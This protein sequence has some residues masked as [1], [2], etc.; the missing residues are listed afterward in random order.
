MTS[1][2]CIGHRGAKGYMPENTL[3]SFKYAMEL[4]CEWLELDV[5]YVDG[6]ILVIHDKRV[7]RTTDGRGL[8][9][10]LELNYLR[11]LDAGN[12]AKIPTLTEVLDLVH[13][14]CGINVE[15]KGRNTARPVCE[16]L[17]NYGWP[18]EKVLLSSFNHEELARSD[19]Q[20]QRGVLFNRLVPDRWQ[21]AEKL[22]ACSVNFYF[23][24]V[25][26]KLVDEAHQRGYKVLV[27]T[28]NELDDIELM[29]AYGVDGIFSDY[30]DRV[31][32]FTQPG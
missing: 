29:L 10:Q 12:G 11:S 30:P 20:Y 1:P 27:Y 2:I 25:T 7:D 14:K 24:H 21:K 16:L 6:E 32:N 9:E 4:G 17:S 8:V 28:V 19:P 23:E 31:L 13:G 22:A 3:P 18:T 15:L 26:Q 5:Y